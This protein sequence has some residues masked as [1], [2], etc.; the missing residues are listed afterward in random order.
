[1]VVEWLT[2]TFCIR[3]TLGLVLKGTRLMN[4]IS[5]LK[6]GFGFNFSVLMGASLKI[7]VFSK[8]EL[9]NVKLG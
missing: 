5:A 6:M 3:R 9:W 2:L 1:M 8:S 7:K 4:S